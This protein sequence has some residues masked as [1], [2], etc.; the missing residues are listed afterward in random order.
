MTADS[1]SDHPLWAKSAVKVVSGTSDEHRLNLARSRETDRRN[2]YEYRSPVFSYKR[3]PNANTHFIPL[4]IS[5]SFL[6][7][8][9]SAFSQSTAMRSTLELGRYRYSV[10]VSVFLKYWLKIV[11][12]WYTPPSI[13]RPC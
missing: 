3:Y 2:D 6:S 1:L 11:N 10:S 9:L 8:Q 5:I 7:S 13:L 4:P 12:F